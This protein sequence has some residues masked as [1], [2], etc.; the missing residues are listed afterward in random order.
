MRANPYR[1]YLGLELSLSLLTGL[2]FATITVYWVSAARLDPLQ[3]LLL[4]TSLELS[5]FVL[6]LPTGVLA[7]MVSRR[8]CV[9]C[10]VF[11]L[12]A[13]LLLQGLST[14]F[15]SMLCAQAVLGL[16]FALIGGAEEA[17]VAS[18]LGEAGITRVYLRG[19]Q[20]GLAG[21]VIG[22]LLSGPVAPASMCPCWPAEACSACWLCCLP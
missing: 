1:L 3:L 12:G 19:T 11:V 7:D 16:G 2:V 13:G 20:V 6:Q 18:E 5:Y 9:I 4:G 21:T 10:G 14:W 15:I 17:W 8:L 22:S